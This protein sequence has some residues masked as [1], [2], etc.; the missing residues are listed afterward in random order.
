MITVER[1]DHTQSPRVVSRGHLAL[2]DLER[3]REEDETMTTST[4]HT[5]PVRR[6]AFDR[7][8]DKGLLLLILAT[9]GAVAACL[10]H[11]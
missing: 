2:L 11:L 3:T 8:F 1:Q 4:M 7:I 6:T 10:A 9:V 5:D